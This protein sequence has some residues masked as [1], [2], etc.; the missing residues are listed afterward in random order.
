LSN[1][2]NI[3]LL[4]ASICG[5]EDDIPKVCCPTIKENIIQTTRKPIIQSTTRK[6]TTKSPS[7][8]STTDFIET[9][10]ENIQSDSSDSGTINEKPLKLPES[11]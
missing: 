9:I 7:T 10:D 5:F 2:R 4:R 11:E 3:R 6:R 8:T 1:K